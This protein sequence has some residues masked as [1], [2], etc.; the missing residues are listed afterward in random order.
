MKNIRFLFVI[1]LVLFCSISKAIATPYF[2]PPEGYK[3]DS[4]TAYTHLYDTEY[5]VC[6]QY[7]NPQRIFLWSLC[8]WYSVV[9]S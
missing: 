4:A 2:C 1:C 6:D 7:K 5:N 9:F 3:Y 8:C